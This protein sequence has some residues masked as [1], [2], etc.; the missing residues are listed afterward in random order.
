MGDRQN[1]S[2]FGYYRDY[3][4]M[5]PELLSRCG[6]NMVSNNNNQVIDLRE[7]PARTVRQH[8]AALHAQGVR[9]FYLNF[10]AHGSEN[11]ITCSWDG[12][13]NS[14]NFSRLTSRELGN[15]LKEFPGCSF[16]I[17]T[18]ACHGGGVL[19]MARELRNVPGAPTVN[20]FT[21]TTEDRTAAGR[22]YFTSMASLLDDMAN[23]RPGAP[24][25]YGEAH[26]RA[27][28]ATGHHTLADGVV[29][30]PQFLTNRP[31]QSGNQ[32]TQ[33]HQPTPTPTQLPPVQHQPTPVTQLPPTHQPPAHPAPHHHQPTNL[34]EMA[35]ASGAIMQRSRGILSQC[36]AMY[37]YA[38]SISRVNPVYAM[39]LGQHATNCAHHCCQWQQQQ[40]GSLQQ[41]N[42][43][44]F[45]QATHMADQ[46]NMIPGFN[47]VGLSQDPFG[48]PTGGPRGPRPNR[49]F[50][51]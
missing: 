8:I 34:I 51:L 10:D 32:I 26:I 20:V 4:R 36:D 11:G 23:H 9:N 47:N 7:D 38:R 41:H 31:D 24:T 48:L 18:D 43:Q 1:R 19:E 30:R 12:P 40:L 33:Q 17:D 15:I 29:R 21:H 46:V 37:A 5:H 22:V 16:T 2:D 27:A 6:Y 3:Q 28:Q 13:N 50:N 44:L 39:R 35:N 45:A 25:T 14:N 49:G 42:P